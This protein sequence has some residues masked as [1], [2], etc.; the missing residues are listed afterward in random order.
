MHTSR[1]NIAPLLDGN[2]IEPDAVSETCQFGTVRVTLTAGFPR[3]AQ[4]SAHATAL[5]Q[6]ESARARKILSVGRLIM[7]R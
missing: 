1:P 2:N 7:C 4:D 5:A 3:K 6:T